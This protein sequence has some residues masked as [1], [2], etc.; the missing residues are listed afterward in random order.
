MLQCT[1]TANIA[2]QANILTNEKPLTGPSCKVQMTS[3][4]RSLFPM[5]ARLGGASLRGWFLRLEWLVCTLDDVCTMTSMGSTSLLLSN[6]TC[7]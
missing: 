2:I 5:S 1:E 7:K 4:R 6:M 3:D